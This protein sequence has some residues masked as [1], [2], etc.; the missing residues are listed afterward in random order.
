MVVTGG[1]NDEVHMG[2]ETVI[3]DVAHRPRII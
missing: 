1:N 3:G 2:P